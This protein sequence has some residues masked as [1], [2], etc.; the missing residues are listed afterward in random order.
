MHI[1]L[2]QLR[3]F[4]AV[5]EE[6]N[7]SR[8]AERLHIAQSALSAQIRALENQVG[9]A[10]FNRTTRK[11]ELTPNGSLLLEE[12]REIVARSDSA[13][14][15]LQAAARGE[16]G[17]LRIGFAAHGGAE[18][19]AAILRRF[20]EEFSGIET[21]L[22][23]SATLEGLQTQLVEHETDVGFVWLP[24]LYDGLEA[25]PVLS[26]RKLIAMH[27]D[28]ALAGKRSV[29]SNELL[30]EPV[31]APWDIYPP[32]LVDYWMGGFRPRGRRPGD[33][34]AMTVEES[35]TIVARGQALYC[36][37]ESAS[38]FYSR[39]EVV[40]KPILDAPPAE[41]AIA[42]A[43]EARNPAVTS[44]VETARAVLT[45]GGEDVATIQSA[46]S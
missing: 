23:Q 19:G 9:C 22:V 42:W 10:L 6:L 21:E 17:L 7:F 28:H 26:E 35:L 8:A 39:P 41:I 24:L 18:P 33:P 46:R 14:A 30:T 43:A 40:F 37:P 25:Q 31:V 4:L 27:A 13:V 44:F 45:E 34:H 16:R 1:E 20:A 3:Y 29:Q 36:V 38:R 15:K 2:R 12:A 11:V 32:E 5:A